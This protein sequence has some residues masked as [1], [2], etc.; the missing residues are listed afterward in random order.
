MAATGVGGG[1]TGAAGAA[2]RAGAGRLPLRFRIP[3]APTAGM[4]FFG[5]P[6]GAGGAGG[7]ACGF[8]SAAGASAV[9]VGA[10]AAG[11]VGAT[12]AGA[13]AAGS[14]GF[15]AGLGAGFASVWIGLSSLAGGGMTDFGGVPG[16]DRSAPPVFGEPFLTRS[17]SASA[18]SCTR[19]L[20]WLVISANPNS[21][22]KSRST[23][24]STFSSFARL[25][26][27]TFFSFASFV[28]G[29]DKRNSSWGCPEQP[30]N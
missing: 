4:K 14:T 26:T 28:C 16:A 23:L 10:G 29:F 5:G 17:F 24:L 1:A 22:Q 7:A 15:G 9:R 13:T 18:W 11:S 2:G 19:P 30:P 8:A 6:G 21:L 20:S 27:R 3:P 25:K 12:G